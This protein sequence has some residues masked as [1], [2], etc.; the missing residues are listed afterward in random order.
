[1]WKSRKSVTGGEEERGESKS[2]S[3]AAEQEHVQALLFIIIKI[4]GNK[5]LDILPSTHVHAAS[6]IPEVT[7]V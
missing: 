6:V 3:A 7:R 5:P 1:M 2:V 4:F